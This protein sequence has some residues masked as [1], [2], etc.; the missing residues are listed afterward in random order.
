M[1]W[2]LLTQTTV[3]I[4]SFDAYSYSD[5]LAL[6]AASVNTFLQHGGRLAWGIVPTG[7]APQ[8][9]RETAR[10]LRR[11]LEERVSAFVRKGISAE[12]LW[13]GML[14]TPSC[15]MGTL[16]TAEASLVFKLLGELQPGGTNI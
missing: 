2:G 4:I 8:L 1:D 7:D 3:N 11:K 6:Y 16:S 10:S 9:Q 14:L 12:Q 15:G 5:K 13:Q